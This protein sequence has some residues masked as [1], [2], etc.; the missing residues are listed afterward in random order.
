MAARSA[1]V[2]GV[3][4]SVA[5]RKLTSVNHV[6]NWLFALACKLSIEFT[7]LFV[8]ETPNPYLSR[9]VNDAFD[10]AKMFSYGS[11]HQALHLKLLQ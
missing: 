1:F 4:V 8:T 10:G 5:V 6:G 3:S 7:R 2:M 9:R 11:K